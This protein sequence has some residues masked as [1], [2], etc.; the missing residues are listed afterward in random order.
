MGLSHLA[1]KGPRNI[2]RNLNVCNLSRSV[3]FISNREEKSRMSL[4]EGARA[5]V[6]FSSPP[7]P[8]IESDKTRRERNCKVAR[9]ELRMKEDELQQRLESLERQAHEGVREMEDPLSHQQQHPQYQR[10][11]TASA[12]ATSPRFVSEGRAQGSAQTPLAVGGANRISL[13][14][15]GGNGGEEGRQRGEGGVGTLR[16]V[17]PTHQ[18]F[19]HGQNS[20]DS[21]SNNVYAN[22]MGVLNGNVINGVNNDRNDDNG[23]RDDHFPQNP[24]EDER[25]AQRGH[26]V[27]PFPSS[28]L[29][30]V[31][32]SPRAS[33][34]DETKRRRAMAL[35]FVKLFVIS[36][37]MGFHV[38]ADDDMQ[39]FLQA[40]TVSS[41]PRWELTA[42]MIQQYVAD[43]YAATKGTF[44]P[45]L[46]QVCTSLQ[47]LSKGRG[48]TYV[49]H[50]T[51]RTFT[52]RCS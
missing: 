29:R 26:A 2:S 7:S 19:L 27:A 22:S 33:R 4:A 30:L 15:A 17:A 21:N 20:V 47:T 41:F 28:S 45:S 35:A 24:Q 18:L 44:A 13:G 25:Q 5:C 38:G 6:V 8:G 34:R 9:T 43:L 1:S 11:P 48:G 46:L 3:Q 51:I 23:D 49:S 36:K 12:D 37:L 32:Q 52:R 39:T 31:T 10:L 50:P 16:G 42:V 40:C 14:D